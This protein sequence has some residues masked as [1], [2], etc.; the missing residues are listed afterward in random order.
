MKQ[1]ILK[2]LILKN[3]KGIKDLTI[4]FSII[5][6]ILGGNGTGKTTIADAFDWLLFD[7]DSQ[8]RVPGDKESNFQIKTYDEAGNIIHFLEHE[9]MSVLSVDGKKLELK[10]TYKEKWTKKRG[11]AEKELTGHET[12]Y[13]ID[14]VPVR[15]QD[16]QS[17]INGMIE[18]NV[19]KLITNPLYFSINMKWQDRR[20]IVLDITGDVSADRVINYK[21]ELEPLAKL[22]DGKDVEDFR[23]AVSAK[24]KKLNENIKAIPIRIDEANNSIQEVDFKELESQ[25]K[26]I[27]SDIKEIEETLL[28]RSKVNEDVLKNKDKLFELKSKLRDM[29]YK[30]KEDAEIPFKKLKEEL[31][32]AEFN[33][34]FEKNKL[35][36]EQYNFTHIQDTI[37]KK[38]AIKDEYSKKWYAENDKKFEFDES[39][40]ECPTC[41]RPLELADIEAKKTELQG[42]F[43]ETKAKNIEEIRKRGFEL[44]AEIE[45]LETELNKSPIEIIKG[46]IT[47]LEKSIEKLNSDIANFEPVEIDSK[48]MED[49]RTQIKDLEA[50]LAAPSDSNKEL[51]EIKLRKSQL[52]GELEEVNKKLASKENNEKLKTRIQE[53][54]TEERKLSEQLAEL[55]KQEFLCEEYTKTKVE[56]LESGI[57][58]KFK[59]VKFKLFNTQVN[60][61]VEEWCEALVDG[62][63][64]S[65]ANTASQ[66]N[67]GLDIIN[68]IS[69]HYGVQAPVLLDNRESVN[70]IIECNS[71]LINL[72]VSDDEELRIE[73]GEM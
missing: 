39:K 69:E 14:E 48:E 73:S 60:G 32:K 56:L 49:L 11:E 30:A 34:Q 9:V 26:N 63:P 52:Q 43:N 64:F 53:L 5:T 62:V 35:S 17:E 70:Q 21:S 29:E 2:Q 55:E 42:N 47:I 36:N 31:N 33:L 41:H 27:Q 68:V 66:V 38:Q 1:I 57:N 72:V 61:A 71:Q 46:T 59:F 22:L 67:A 23:K 19:F 25:K 7:K 6:D 18:E 3:F 24:K 20:K 13:Y 44:K 16:Y 28:D 37:K 58:E 54:M 40:C 10:K 50:K 12:I 8:D 65:N 4:D 51:Q 45:Q 15:K